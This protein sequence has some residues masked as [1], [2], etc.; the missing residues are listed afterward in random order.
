MAGQARG[1]LR[2]SSLWVTLLLLSILALAV[3]SPVVGSEVLSSFFVVP[4][5]SVVSF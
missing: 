2:L 1:D 4:S 3:F 5:C